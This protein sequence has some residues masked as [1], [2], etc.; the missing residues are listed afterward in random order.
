[1]GTLCPLGAPAPQTAG[2][3][4]R[5]RSPRSCWWCW[6]GGSLSVFRV[7]FPMEG[8]SRCDVPGTAP[9]FPG[10]EDEALSFPALLSLSGGMRWTLTCGPALGCSLL[11]GRQRET[12]AQCGTQGCMGFLRDVNTLLPIPSGGFCLP[13]PSLAT[14]HPLGHTRHWLR[15]QWG[16]GHT[17]SPCPS[18]GPSL[19]PQLSVHLDGVPVVGAVQPWGPWEPAPGSGP[20]PAGCAGGWESTIWFPTN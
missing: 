20:W 18:A 14:H 17:D 15:K 11:F 2:E 16:R 6:D 5:A 10:L 13:S 4:G 1:M 7:V 19:P 8:Y 9:F 12:E 3:W